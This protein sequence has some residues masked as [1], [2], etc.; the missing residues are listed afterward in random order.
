MVARVLF[1]CV[2]NSCRSQMAEGL[3]RA[4]GAG[5][6]EPFSAGSNPCGYVDPGAIASMREAGIDIST[7]R[8]KGLSDVPHDMDYVVTMGCG[9]V[10][11]FA[12][13]RE[14]IAWVLPDPRGKSAEDYRVIRDAIERRVRELIDRVR[15]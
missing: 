6:L 3:A 7:H 8:S 2:H 14:R 1:L 5:V 10:C 4:F 12:P 13:A 15:G 9:D 11:P